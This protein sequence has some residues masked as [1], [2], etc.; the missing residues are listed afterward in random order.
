[1]GGIRSLDL[2]WMHG[3]TAPTRPARE[4]QGQLE[5]VGQTQKKLAYPPATRWTI[6]SSADKDIFP[7][8]V[9]KF[10]ACS[11]QKR[12]NNSQQLAHEVNNR[13]S[14][15]N[16]CSNVDW[17]YDQVTCS[18]HVKANQARGQGSWPDL[19][20]QRRDRMDRYP[21][22]TSRWLFDSIGCGS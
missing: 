3:R 1:M 9:A 13:R 12:E 22:D 19:G 6:V 20:S 8:K 16:L 21:I 11:G 18:G 5:K 10:V 14:A 15:R 2:Q 7:C 17:M 4:T